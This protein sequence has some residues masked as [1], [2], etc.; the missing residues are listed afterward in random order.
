MCAGNMRVLSHRI[1]F[2][3]DNNGGKY[4]LDLEKLKLIAEINDSYFYCCAAN[5]RSTDSYYVYRGNDLPSEAPDNMIVIHCRK[6]WHNG[7]YGV[8][9]SSTDI[10]FLDEKEM[11]DA[12]TQD[13]NERKNLNLKQ[14]PL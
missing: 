6:P 5:I 7:N 8:L 2:Y 12:I 3:K 14:K 1:Y 9:L 11:K 10:L 13:N 4:P